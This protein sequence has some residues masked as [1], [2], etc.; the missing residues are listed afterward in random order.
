MSYFEWSGCVIWTQKLSGPFNT[1][2]RTRKSGRIP[3]ILLSSWYHGEICESILISSPLQDTMTLR[4]M[5]S[6]ISYWMFIKASQIHYTG[7]LQNFWIQAHRGHFDGTYT[8][9]NLQELTSKIYLRRCCMSIK[10]LKDLSKISW[11]KT[12]W[13]FMYS[14]RHYKTWQGYYMPLFGKLLK[15]HVN[16]RCLSSILD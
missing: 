7:I 9:M 16:G 5:F 2:R 3:A 11:E 4:N 1:I 6:R 12:T 13:P 14:G 10:D 15:V 8:Y